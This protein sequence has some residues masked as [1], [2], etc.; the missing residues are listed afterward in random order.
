MLGETV[1]NENMKYLISIKENC[2][3][4]NMYS[5]FKGMLCKPAIDSKIKGQK[6]S[7]A[8]A[9]SIYTTTAS[10]AD[11]STI[12]NKG[13]NSNIKLVQKHMGTY[14]KSVDPR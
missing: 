8:I 5:I 6:K 7:N 2:I 9:E 13:T 10:N 4:A 12:K 3:F 11:K 1:A 14:V